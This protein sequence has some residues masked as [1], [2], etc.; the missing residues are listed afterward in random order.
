[1]NLRLTR[2]PD[3]VTLTLGDERHTLHGWR[4]GGD[5]GVR[6]ATTQDGHL[7][8]L[9]VWDGRASLAV[10]TRQFDVAGVQMTPAGITGDATEI[11]DTWVQEFVDRMRARVG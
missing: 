3:A 8:T 9:V 6:H 11:A 7:V 2:T 10:G 5:K 1:M 4:Q